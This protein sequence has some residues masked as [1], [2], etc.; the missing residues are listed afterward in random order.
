MVGRVMRARSRVRSNRVMR[1]RSGN[2]GYPRRV[3]G[4]CD[5]GTKAASGPVRKS[6]VRENFENKETRRHAESVPPLCLGGCL[7]AL[8]G[9]AWR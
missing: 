6:K 7:R 1:G 8:I 3:G 5:R 4:T 2:G 9:D